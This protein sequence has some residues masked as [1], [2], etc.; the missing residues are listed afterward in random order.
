MDR[1]LVSDS[2]INWFKDGEKLEV[3]TQ[4]ESLPFLGESGAIFEDEKS[5]CGESDHIL[6]LANHS[7]VLCSIDQSDIGYYHCEVE[8]KSE[9]TK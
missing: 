3:E 7:L 4:P 2:T 8:M 1:F 6:I 5:P 9:R